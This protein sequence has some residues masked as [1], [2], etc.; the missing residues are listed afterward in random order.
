MGIVNSLM[1]KPKGEIFLCCD[2]KIATYRCQ[3][4]DE[5]ILNLCYYSHC[6]NGNLNLFDEPIKTILMDLKPYWKSTCSDTIQWIAC[7]K[8]ITNKCKKYFTYKEEGWKED[9]KFEVLYEI[10]RL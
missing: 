10:I 9:I 3:Y 5:K 8:C 7:D 2:K 1:N 6:K 4:S